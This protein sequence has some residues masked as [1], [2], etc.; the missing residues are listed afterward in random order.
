[1]VHGAGEQRLELA[2]A[3]AVA[4]GRQ[5]AQRVAVIALP[6]GDDMTALRLAALQEILP[7]QLDRRLNGFR[8]AGNEIDAGNARR[9]PFNQHLGQMF[10][11]LGGEEAGM[12]VGDTIQLRLDGG[13]HGTVGMTEAGYRR[14]AASVEI[15]AIL[16]INQPNA[17]AAGDN[18][19]IGP[20][21][22]RKDEL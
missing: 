20:G 11:R 7:G 13:K 5:C 1:M 18:R 22:A 10:G 16:G 15:A 4:A 8:S 9:R 19:Q 6:A 12:G 21:V 3:P 17:V 14:A 2:A